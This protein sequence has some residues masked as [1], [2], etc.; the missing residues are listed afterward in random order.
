LI[1]VVIHIF[2]NA[3]SSIALQLIP[4]GWRWFR[5]AVHGEIGF[6]KFREEIASAFSGRSRQDN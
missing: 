1:S 2:E 5:T 6:H 4:F 3:I